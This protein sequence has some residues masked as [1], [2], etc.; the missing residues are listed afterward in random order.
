MASG[1]NSK[2][3]RHDNSPESEDGENVANFDNSRMII[4]RMA[5]LY[6]EK[7]MNDII[8]VIGNDE[9]PSHKLILCASSDVFQIMLHGSKWSESNEKRVTLGEKP[10]CAAVF[11]DFLKYLYT[12]KI[13]LNFATVVPI[14][15]LADKYNVKDLLQ[16][17]L[18]YMERNVS[19]ACKKNQVVSWF[20]LTIASG[21]THVANLCSNF[22]KSNFEMVS[23][24]IDFPRMEPELLIS[25]IR[26]N[27]LVIH[28]EF[29]LFECISRWLT[30][31][32]AFMESTGE[33]NI[34]MHF[35]RYVD[36]VMSYVRFPM[37][38]QHQLSDLLLNPLS[39]SH[40][41]MILDKIRAG[42]RFHKGGEVVD[43]A[44]IDN[45]IYTP[46]LYT[47]EKF[48]ASLCVDHFYELPSYHCRSLLFSSQRYNAENQG[49]DQ[50]D[51]SVDLYPKG[52][53]FQRCLTVY[54]PSGKE[55][56]ERVIKTV[57]ASVKIKLSCENDQIEMGMPCKCQDEIRVKIGILIIGN[58]DK[59]EHV[60]CVR[61]RNFVFSHE[62]EIV[63][64]DDIVDFEEL[65]TLK[66]K[67]QY[68][69]GE[70]GE[71]LKILL[72]IT[73]LSKY[74]SLSVT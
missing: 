16:L 41:N 43:L 64:F 68:L 5:T 34:D 55:V 44:G 6:A 58:Q 52:V 53:W 66:P 42:L 10:E 1:E 49:E 11:E 13:H 70:N 39:D 24:T 3:F 35:D 60:R 57:R 47:A 69:S 31:R 40:T 61:T 33:E 19:L 9:Y 73:P 15:S 62:S 32:K 29:K 7:I 38:T 14:V 72:T 45:R 28:D 21:H 63:N 12:G 30:S 2:S 46:R 56:P 23:K 71:S 67:S 8:L 54:K 65:L 50:L 51:W 4:N 17:G 25:L 36:L 59:F 27:D 74:S 48:C 37:M 20:Q 18:G 26:C 22:I